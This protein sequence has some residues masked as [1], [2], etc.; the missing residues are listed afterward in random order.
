VES[1]EI[2]G[3]FTVEFKTPL[4]V[5][6]MDAVELPVMFRPT[7]TGEQSGRLRIK[8]NDAAQPTLEVLLKG[9][10]VNSYKPQLEATPA[11][12]DFGTVA[13]AG[14]EKR[15][16]RLLNRGPAPLEVKGWSTS[17]AAFAVAALE[18]PFTLRIGESFPLT[19]TFTPTA[20]GPK[21]AKLTVESNDPKFPKMEVALRASGN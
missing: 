16:V 14:S 12:V 7:A 15:E 17:D 19:L 1:A 10:G 5:G 6:A 11:S 13:V 4:R 2:T 20:G 9:T 3:P 21:T 18:K 8:S